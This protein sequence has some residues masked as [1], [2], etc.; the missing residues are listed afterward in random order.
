MIKHE[1]NNQ[2]VNYLHIMMLFI[3]SAI[4]IWSL[5]SPKDL[6]TWFLEALPVIIGLIVILATY[7]SFR[8]TN[9]VYVFILVHAIILLIGAHYTYAEMPFFNWLRDY[10]NLSRN[11]YD[12]LGH[13]AQGFVP[14]MISREILLRKSSLK[15]GKLLFFLI[16]CICLAISASYELIEW[17]VAEATG[18]AA[19]AF[20]GTQGDVWDTQWDMFFALL[21]AICSLLGLSRLHDSFLYRAML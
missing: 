17:V 7:N 19:D 12:R 6:F 11:Y 8:L 10:L 2:E 16:I 15:R 13:F 4:F 1:K 3:F 20:L 18:S 14:A 9:L 21:G 5:I